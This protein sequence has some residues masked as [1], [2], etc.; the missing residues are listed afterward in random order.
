MLKRLQR[1]V[2][3]EV[4]DKLQQA[5]QAFGGSQNSGVDRELVPAS[6]TE[7][8]GQGGQLPLLNSASAKGVDAHRDVEPASSS[9]PSP[10]P[11][12]I[13]E[14]DEESCSIFE[15]GED[16][17]LEPLF[18]PGIDDLAFGAVVDEPELVPASPV[19]ASSVV[20][21]FVDKAAPAVAAEVVD[22]VLGV[23][24]CFN[25]AVAGEGPI[26]AILVVD[27][28]HTR[29]P[30]I[31]WAYPAA[32]IPEEGVLGQT[33]E[34]H[35][36][37]AV[38][39]WS[40]PTVS[41]NATHCVTRALQTVSFLA[42]PDGAHGESSEETSS[43]F[44]VL[45]YNSGL[46]YGVSC[47]RR[48]GSNDLLHRDSSVSRGFV[49]KAVCVLSHCP[50]FCMIQERLSPVTHCWF[51]QKDFRSTAL[52]C[53]FHA[54][55]DALAFEKLSESHLF[56]GIDHAILFRGLKFELLCVLKAVL[57]EAK[58]VIYSSSAET[59]SRVVLC[60]LSLLPG[61]LWFSFNSDGFGGRHFHLRKHGLPFECFGPHCCVHPYASLHML[62]KL[63]HMKGFLVGATN[64]VLVDR[65]SPDLILEVPA[66][67]F[68]GNTSV[69]GIKMDYLN[70]ELRQLVRCT[71]VDRSWLNEELMRLDTAAPADSA[72]QTHGQGGSVVLPAAADSGVTTPRVGTVESRRISGEEQLDDVDDVICQDS[73]QTVVRT[74][75]LSAPEQAHKKVAAWT[76]ALQSGLNKID[77]LA[78]RGAGSASGASG[79]STLLQQASW[80][81][82]VDAS[83]CAFWSYFD[84]MVAAAASVAG[85]DRCFA[86]GLE[87]ASH[88]DRDNAS[89]R[90]GLP[91]LQRWSESTRSGRRCLREHRLPVS[92]ERR[93]RPPTSGAGTYR[94]PNGDEYRGEFRRGQRHGAGVYVST[95]KRMHYDGEWSAD[96]RSGS[97]LLTVDGPDGK[98]LY[99]YDGE[100]QCDQRHGRGSCVRCGKEKYSGQWAKNL[101][102]GSGMLANEEGALYEGEWV[103]GEL[104][105]VGK[106]TVGGE[107][108]TGEFLAGKRHGMGQLVRNTSDELSK[109]TTTGP[110]ESWE[111]SDCGLLG[112]ERMFVGQ[113]H[114][115]KRHGNGKALYAHAEFDGQ[116]VDGRRHG[117]GV[118]LSARHQFEGAWVTDEVEE[119]GMHMIFFPDGSKYTGHVRCQVRFGG[120]SPSQELESAVEDVR[121]ASG[122]R[123]GATI[124]SVTANPSTWLLPEG[125]G[126]MKFPDGRLYDGDYSA[127]L[128]HGT[129]LFMDVDR[130]QYEGGFAL[131]Q[132]HGSGMVSGPAG[133]PLLHVTYERG[134]LLSPPGV[135]EDVRQIDVKTENMSHTVVAPPATP[136]QERLPSTTTSSTVEDTAVCVEP[137]DGLVPPAEQGVVAAPFLSHDT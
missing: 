25:R 80:S 131:G 37:P 78:K 32:W 50:F 7:R 103:G 64:R 83:R 79:V 107:T 29:G 104:S 98:I 132:R 1:Y 61:G 48:V 4:K 39:P 106:S 3:A 9:A 30:T 54:Q 117:Q 15:I 113:W 101:Y 114:E 129:G 124:S 65:S 60:L 18:E 36:F 135:S 67:S 128:F 119:H 5:Q 31:E 38:S 27:F 13:E 42:L 26:V 136:N 97:G 73:T 111:H 47:H 2:P 41:S 71:S 88:L 110:G 11:W 75:A 20:A 19:L 74:S 109:L 44:F 120:S 89:R 94:F 116:W 12:R 96:R 108:Y 115:G 66:D 137:T 40:T 81:A 112:C 55:L 134:E 91:F 28:H 82:I 133:E 95:R 53:D 23:G 121:E 62:D 76:A 57:L 33:S 59:C 125:R 45:P 85:A 49:Q 69:G 34:P 22:T 14:D 10:E 77:L 87:S 90:F 56:H 72:A 93:S 51:E 46:L 8:G 63:I 100:W 92:A 118:L 43:V 105:G 68:G 16:D 126:L 17:I 21:S 70:K 122:V 52:L 123:R 127:G 84:Q 99:T 102:H 86:G 35:S 130:S 24:F 58:V 6:P